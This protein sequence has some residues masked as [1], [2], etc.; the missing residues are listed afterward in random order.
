[1]TA[2]LDINRENW[3]SFNRTFDQYF[4]AFTPLVDMFR[5]IEH[6]NAYHL[7]IF[8]DKKHIE[9]VK[10][11]VNSLK[12][13]T[14]IDIDEK[15]LEN[16]SILWKRLPRETEI[17]NSQEYRKLIQHR[18]SHPENNNP[19]YTLIN[20][21]KI[22]FV[23]IATK[24]IPCEYFCWVDFGYC[25]NPVN[26]PRNPIDINRLDKSRIN[27]TLINPINSLDSNILYTL[28]NAPEKIGGFFFFGSRERIIEYQQLYHSIHEA[29]QDRNI[30]DDDQHIALQCCFAKPSLFALHNVGG[31][32]KA[33]VAFQKQ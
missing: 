10:L 6:D 30:V 17:V 14:I 25:S 22:D 5:K 20:H 33:L 28:Q 3:S 23:N 24:L 19:R 4:Q 12:N 27:Y 29:F 16:N 9:R 11:Y 31:W 7:V 1:V 15:Y 8:A 13:I 26:I 32:H 18:I 21:A 2:F